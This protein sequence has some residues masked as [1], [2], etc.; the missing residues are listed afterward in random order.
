MWFLLYL[1]SIRKFYIIGTEIQLYIPWQY[2]KSG[3]PFEI[4]KSPSLWIL[5]QHSLY[6]SSWYY[7]MM[8]PEWTEWNWF[9]AVNS[10]RWKLCFSRTLIFQEKINCIW[11]QWTLMKDFKNERINEVFNSGNLKLHL[12]AFPKQNRSP[13]QSWYKILNIPDQFYYLCDIH[14]GRNCLSLN[15]CFSIQIQMSFSLIP[16][17]K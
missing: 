12:F 9:A 16:T 5:V 2:N 13:D 6:V 11:I 10:I 7:W 3:V 1:S 8:I 17:P 14:F 4:R 15:P